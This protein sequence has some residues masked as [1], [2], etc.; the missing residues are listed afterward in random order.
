MI[1]VYTEVRAQDD[2]ELLKNVPGLR[3]KV[4][5][6]GNWHVAVACPELAENIAEPLYYVIR[7]YWTTPT[8]KSAEASVKVFRGQ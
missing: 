3:H 4:P 8:H 7:A 2:D 5:E 1:V 6:D